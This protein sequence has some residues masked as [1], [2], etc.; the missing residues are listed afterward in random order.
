MDLN[1]GQQ[2]TLTSLSVGTFPFLVLTSFTVFTAGGGPELGGGGLDSLF[3]A[4]GFSP[5]S[6]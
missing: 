2:P 5:V 1:I 3:F 6:S 4:P